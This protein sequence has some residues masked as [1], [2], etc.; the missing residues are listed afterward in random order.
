MELIYKIEDIIESKDALYKIGKE[1]WDEVDQMS[2]EAPFDPDWDQYEQMNNAGMVRYYTAYDGNKL[3]GF[4]IFVISLSLHSKGMYIAS[5][6]CVYLKKPYRGKGAEFINLIQQDLREQKVKRFSLN[7]KA[8]MDTGRLAP[9]IGCEH[10]ENVL[11]R[12]L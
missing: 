5:S 12:S 9:A 3:I 8:W 2:K 7:I 11:E 4:G 6:D 1:C 10:Y